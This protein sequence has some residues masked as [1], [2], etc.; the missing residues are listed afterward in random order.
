MDRSAVFMRSI[1]DLRE[2][3][4][5][6]SRIKEFTAYIINKVNKCRVEADRVTA[7]DCLDYFNSLERCTLNDMLEISYILNGGVMLKEV[8]RDTDPFLS[9]SLASSPSPPI[10]TDDEVTV[11]TGTE[12]GAAEDHHNDVGT[13][14]DADRE[15]QRLI[16]EFEGISTEQ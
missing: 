7:S 8:A 14:S 16:S 12:A 10:D 11:N 6:P 13:D 9:P 15:F 2:T 3:E 1:Q 4:C 5:E